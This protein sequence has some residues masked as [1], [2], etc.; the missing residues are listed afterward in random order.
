MVRLSLESTHIFI[1][2]FSEAIPS[3]RSDGGSLPEI[4]ELISIHVKCLLV[5]KWLDVS[6]LSLLATYKMYQQ[7]NRLGMFSW[8]VTL[9]LSINYMLKDLKY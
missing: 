4:D 3:Q 9:P 8:K 6:C 5:T 2:S 7:I 1:V